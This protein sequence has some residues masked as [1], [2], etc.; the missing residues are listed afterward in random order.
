MSR[1]DPSPTPAALR[2]DRARFEALR[3]ELAELDWFRRGSLSEIWVRCGRPRCPCATDPDRRHGPKVQWTRKV[4]GKTVTVRMRKGEQ[5]RV[6]GWIA[7]SRRLDQIVQEMH[8]LSLRATEAI[9]ERERAQR[10]PPDGPPQIP[11]VK[12]RRSARDRPSKSKKRRDSR[13]VK[14]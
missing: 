6:E 4:R 7:N 2:R 10:P 12:K 13:G 14:K 8:E 9:L 3:R 1:P 11:G 5:E